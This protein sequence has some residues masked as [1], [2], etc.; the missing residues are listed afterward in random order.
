MDVN[1]INATVAISGD[2]KE[3]SEQGFVFPIPDKDLPW[4]LRKQA[5]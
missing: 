5:V 3:V 2:E 1:A 4:M